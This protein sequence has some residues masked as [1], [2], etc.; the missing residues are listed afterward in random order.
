M[1]SSDWTDPRKIVIG[2]NYQINKNTDIFNELNLCISTAI[3]EFSDFHKVSMETLEHEHY[4]FN[5]RSYM[6]GVK[7]GAHTDTIFNTPDMKNGI[8]PFAVICLYLSSNFE[9]GEI[10]FPDIDF[11]LKPKAGTMVIFKG[12]VLHEVTELISGDRYIV[13][14]DFLKKEVDNQPGYSIHKWNDDEDEH[15]TITP[16]LGKYK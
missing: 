16:F 9:G 1:P 6:P 4:S 5:I 14:V 13:M 10:G 11:Y 7:M 2:K 3:S 15:P 8:E 12:N